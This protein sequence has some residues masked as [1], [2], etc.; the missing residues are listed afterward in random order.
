LSKK[1]LQKILFLDFSFFEEKNRRKLE[2]QLTDLLLKLRLGL[3]MHR[4]YAEEE[5]MF[6]RGYLHL[7]CKYGER[8]RQFT[9]FEGFLP[10]LLHRTRIA[11]QVFTFAARINNT[12]YFHPYLS[13]FT[14]CALREAPYRV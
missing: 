13:D 9:P 10:R 7:D 12:A 5:C 4:T 6:A 14:G 3:C 11:R 8:T 2:I 1:K